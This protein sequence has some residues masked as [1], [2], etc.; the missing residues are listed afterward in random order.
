MEMNGP[1]NSVGFMV[2]LILNFWVM[3]VFMY[4]AQFYGVVSFLFSLISY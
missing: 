1:V 4:E 3:S 2:M